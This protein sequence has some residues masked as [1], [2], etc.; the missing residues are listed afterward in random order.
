MRLPVKAREAP[1][2]ARTNA[3]VKP[4]GFFSAAAS[5]LDADLVLGALL[6]AVALVATAADFLKGEF[7]APPLAFCGHGAVAIEA[8]ATLVYP[9]PSVTDDRPTLA[10]RVGHLHLVYFRLHSRDVRPPHP[11]DGGWRST[12][13]LEAAMVRV[14]ASLPATSVKDKLHASFLS[15]AARI[16]H[17][18]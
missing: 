16:V 3:N 13:R 5:E 9:T 15:H 1:L 18:T 8:I 12:E 2:A 6:A 10:L 7:H 14:A 17:P 11:F 4:P